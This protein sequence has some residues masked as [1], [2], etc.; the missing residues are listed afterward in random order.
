MDMVIAIK[1]SISWMSLLCLVFLVNSPS[2]ESFGVYD[3][4]EFGI[5][6]S[7]ELHQ[8]LHWNLA[9]SSSSKTHIFT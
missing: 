2:C 5:H 3:I 7:S 9:D 4:G 1:P 8:I 6:I